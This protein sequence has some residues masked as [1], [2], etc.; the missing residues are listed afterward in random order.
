MMRL[1]KQ[2]SS[3]LWV[4]IRNILTV[5]GVLAQ[6]HSGLNRFNEAELIH[7]NKRH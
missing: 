5:C 4:Q 7:D 6:H 2:L 1:G 3:H